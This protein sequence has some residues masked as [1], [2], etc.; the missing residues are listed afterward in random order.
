MQNSKIAERFLT[1]KEQ[2]GWLIQ[3][4]RHDRLWAVDEASWDRIINKNEDSPLLSDNPYKHEGSFTIGDVKEFK[5]LSAPISISWAITG[6][7]NSRCCF[8][9]TSDIQSECAK[10]E[11]DINT[12][13]QTLKVLLE[14]KVPRIIIGGGEPLIRHDI[15]DILELFR[16]NS[17]KPVI[18]TNGIMLHGSLLEQVAQTCM[19]IQISLDTLDPVVYQKLRGVDALSSV[20]HNLRD[21]VQTGSLV[22]VVTVLNRYNEY[23]LEKIGAYL[24]HIGIKQWFIFE[25][26]RSGRGAEVYDTLH[27]QD[28]EHV[29]RTIQKLSC[30]CPELSI[31]YWGNK[32]QD[33]CAV[34]VMPDGRLGLTDYH[35]NETHYFSKGLLTS[36]EFFRQWNCIEYPEK[37]KML[38]NFTSANRMEQ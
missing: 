15:S 21:T 23:E 30:S 7:C 4:T 29:R 24:D 37:R 20:M 22:R 31:W 18:A 11:A 25:M 38:E 1:R 14:M 28:M 13:E 12:I 6:K 35:R 5:S 9:C 33:G 17:F 10:A 26:L 27:V 3:D 8:C 2:W 34:Y 36:E 32:P 19:N 16:R